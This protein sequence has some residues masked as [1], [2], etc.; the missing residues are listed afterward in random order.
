[1]WAV[2]RITTES[3]NQLYLSQWKRE[4]EKIARTLFLLPSLCSLSLSLSAVFRL[5]RTLLL[6]LLK[7]PLCAIKFKFSSPFF[8]F[9]FFFSFFFSSSHISSRL[10]ISGFTLSFTPSSGRKKSHRRIIKWKRE[11]ESH[12]RKWREMVKRAIL[13][14]VHRDEEDED[15]ADAFVAFAGRPEETKCHL[16]LT[17]WNAQWV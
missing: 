11:R 14:R 5:L 17:V 7:F 10:S 9:L 8:F 6:R 16:I 13:I 15:G 12:L 1:M 4:T 3:Y 2:T